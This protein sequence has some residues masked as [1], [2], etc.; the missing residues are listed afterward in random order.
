MSTPEW[1]EADE[2][3]GILVR[4]GLE[5]HHRLEGHPEAIDGCPICRAHG[6]CS[7]RGPSEPDGCGPPP[8]SS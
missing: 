8:A 7:R 4:A 3:N 2:S 6:R 1:E 5:I